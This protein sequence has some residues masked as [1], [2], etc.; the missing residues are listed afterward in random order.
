VLKLVTG[1]GKEVHW[2]F[3]VISL[4]LV[5]RYIFVPPGG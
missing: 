3:H 1:R 5:L 4:V 2:A